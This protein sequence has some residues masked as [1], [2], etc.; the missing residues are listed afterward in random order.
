MKKMIDVRKFCEK[1]E[2]ANPYLT[3][4][5]VGKNSV[6]CQ[7]AKRVVIKY[8]CEGKEDKFCQDVEIGCFLI[9]EKL[10]MRLKLA[11]RSLTQE[12]YL[13]CHFDIHSTKIEL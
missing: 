13:N 10:A 8:E 3:R 11:H 12:K 9:R 1:K 6:L 5:K 4:G 7:S 2:A